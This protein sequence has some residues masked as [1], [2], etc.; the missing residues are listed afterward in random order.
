[1]ANCEK[2][3]AELQ[4]GVEHTC[5]APVAE[6]SAEEAAASAEPGS[7]ETTA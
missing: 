1:M 7:E 6:A 2:C 5:E 4:E 3:S